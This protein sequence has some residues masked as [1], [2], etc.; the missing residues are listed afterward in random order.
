MQFWTIVNENYL[1]YLRQKESRIPISDYG[2]NKFKPFFGVLFEH[3]GL[4]FLTQISH[5]KPKHIPMKNSL[6]FHKIFLPDKDPLAPDRLVAVVNLNYMFPVP[7]TYFSPLDYR[8][9]SNHR[10]F[11]SEKDKSSYIDLLRKELSVINTMNLE[12]KAQKVYR[13]KKDLPNSSISKRC[14]NFELLE[15]YAHEYNK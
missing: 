11:T 4:Y 6:D 12:T 14:L 3:N 1:D 10:T 7:K 9:I 13:L 5:A 15:R 2:A 8:D